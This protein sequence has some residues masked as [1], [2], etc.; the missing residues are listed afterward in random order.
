MNNNNNNNDNE[1]YNLNIETYTLKDLFQLFDIP[2]DKNISLENLKKAKKK[3]LMAHP[4]K[5]KLP[6]EFFL[7]YKK[8]FD[9][10]INFYNNQTKQNKEVGKEKIAYNSEE[11]GNLEHESQV[12]EEIEKMSKK[13]FH[14]KFNTLFEQTMATKPDSSKNEWFSNINPEFDIREPVSKQNMNIMFNKIKEKQ[15]G[16]IIYKGVEVL[17]GNIGTRLYDDP[18]DHNDIDENGNYTSSSNQYVSCDPFSKLKYDD[19]RKVHKD[20]T[21]FTVSEDD[22]KK[23][24]QYS[25]VE[26]Y[27]QKRNSDVLTP[28][29]KIEAE[30]LISQKN[31]Q[32]KQYI[33]QQEYLSEL[34]TQ[35]N[36]E[37]NKTVLSNFLRI[38]N[39]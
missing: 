10:V 34:N 18:D 4:D 29:D 30:K 15:N 6:P 22:I 24:P 1:K 37:K 5:S 12:K 25:S 16:I 23:I 39:N 21:V 3:V 32:Y 19:L 7:F 36:M 13:D 33:Q 11:I 8:A 2:F 17:S 38:M 28:M 31:N 9:I 14:N 26:K 35:S 20:Q 27:S